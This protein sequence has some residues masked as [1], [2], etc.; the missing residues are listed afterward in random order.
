M[1]GISKIVAIALLVVITLTIVV[2]LFA[3]SRSTS[4]KD[5]KGVDA[6]YDFV[7]DTVS[8]GVTLEACQGIKSADSKYVTV[9]QSDG[10]LVVYNTNTKTPIW[11]TDAV[12]GV[13]SNVP[14][15]TVY[16]TDSNMVMY[17][18]TNSPIW[19]SNTAGRFSNRVIMQDDGNLVM[20]TAGGTPVWSTDTVGK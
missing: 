14:N 13:G 5:C 8:P 20:Y 16:Q 3:S 17:D 11:T 1:L 18:K 12:A 7:G 10:N 15:R 2:I 4:S 9:Q 19:A 6:T